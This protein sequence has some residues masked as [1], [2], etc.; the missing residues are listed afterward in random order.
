MVVLRPSR[1][2]PPSYAGTPASELLLLFGL[3]GAPTMG[4]HTVPIDTG[5]ASE[6]HPPSTLTPDEAIYQRRRSPSIHAGSASMSKDMRYM[7]GA[8][9]FWAR[10]PSNHASEDCHSN[11]CASPRGTWQL[12]STSSDG[13]ALTG[14]LRRPLYEPHI[15]IRWDQRI[16][17]MYLESVRVGSSQDSGISNLWPKHQGSMICSLS[18]LSRVSKNQAQ[19][20]EPEQG[21]L[22]QKYQSQY[23]D[24]SYTTSS[25]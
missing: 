21:S 2:H 7:R 19:I 6:T 8:W 10:D 25:T 17:V 3:D 9:T 24:C 14:S 20:V 4:S 5:Q 23:H 15:E 11:S 18:P 16:S 13:N 22:F 12:E 1:A